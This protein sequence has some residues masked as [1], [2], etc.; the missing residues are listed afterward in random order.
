MAF[1]GYDFGYLV[2]L[3]TAQSLPSNET[4]FF[5]AL[6]TWFP[7]TF[8]VKHIMKSCKVLKGGLQDVADELGVFSS[9]HQFFN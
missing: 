1:S 7:T 8:D 4:E 6:N 3:L 5:E 2:K 9:R